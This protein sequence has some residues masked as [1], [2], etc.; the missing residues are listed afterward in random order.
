MAKGRYTS[1]KIKAVKTETNMP[2]GQSYCRRCS[3]V[4]LKM[5]FHKCTDIDVDTNGLWSICKSCIDE[6]YSVFLESENSHQKATLRMCKLLNLEYNEPALDSALKQANTRGST[7]IFGYYR[8]KLLI[9]LRT[10]VKDTNV[11]YSYKDNP[12][13]NTGVVTPNEDEVS[14]DVI[15]FWGNGYETENYRWLE[16]ELDSWKMT[17]KCDTKGEETLL[18]EIVFKQFEIEK[19][20]GEQANTASLVKEL[21]DL[22]KTASVDPSKSNNMGAGKNDTFSA[23][24]KLIES[25]EPAE[26]FGDER[27]AFAD[28]SGIGFYFEKYVTRPLRN[29]ILQS[30]D[31]NVDEDVDGETDYD[32]TDENIP[33]LPEMKLE[34]IEEATE[35]TDDEESN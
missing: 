25:G 23:F 28:F 6:M 20:R 2:D 9:Q 18:K 22:M 13:V 26:I 16:A 34:D 7:K 4:K 29:F 3:K 33:E 31:F 19:A 5:H 24:I 8:A 32:F 10:S 21:Q 14:P 1:K 12:V 17:H 15:H 35:V 27:D 30:R 11:D